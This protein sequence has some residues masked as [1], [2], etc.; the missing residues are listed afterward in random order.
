M[1]ILIIG[2]S[3]GIGLQLLEQ[4][5]AQGHT[6]TALVRDPQK[7]S[8]QRERLKVVKGD[9]RPW[10]SRARDGRSGR[11]MLHHRD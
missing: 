9:I 1:N 11:C 7:L 5:L 2:A 3:R 8:K 6:V 10:F 4:A